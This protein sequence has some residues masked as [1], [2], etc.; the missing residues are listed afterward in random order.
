MLRSVAIVVR[1]RTRLTVRILLALVPGLLTIAWAFVG[2]ELHSIGSAAA[3]GNLE[4]D[5]MQDASSDL[6][7][8][9]Q[10]WTG[11]FDGMFERRLIRALVVYSKTAFFYDQGRP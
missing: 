7:I 10:H 4:S 2:I 8:P 6:P 1:R 11:D 5:S 3:K 9:N